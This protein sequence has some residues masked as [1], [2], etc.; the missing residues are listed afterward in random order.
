MS[1]RA[2]ITYEKDGI[3]RILYL[4]VFYMLL[5]DDWKELYEKLANLYD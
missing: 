2:K 1:P 5:D 4:I 3:I